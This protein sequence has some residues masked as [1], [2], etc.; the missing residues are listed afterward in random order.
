MEGTPFG[1]STAVLG[2]RAGLR[3]LLVA[4][5]AATV[6]LVLLAPAQ[7]SAGRLVATGHDADIHCTG[8]NQP[9]EGQCGFMRVATNYVRAGSSAPVLS[10]D[11]SGGSGF[12]GNVAGALDGAFGAGVVPRVEKCP[13]NPSD[14]FASEP[15]TTAR[16]S[17]IIVGSSCVGSLN[18]QDCFT[19]TPDSDAINARRDDIIAFF[20]AGGG[21]LALAGSEN[22]DGDPATGPDTYYG[23]LPLP[24]GGV[25]VN[26]PFCLTAVGRSL[27]LHD[28]SC[29]DTS[30]H[31]GTRDDINCCATHNSFTEPPGGS[32]LL[33]AE[34]D[35]GP[36]GV[37]SAGDAP[38][39]LIA[40]GIASGGTIVLPDTT[41]PDT[42]IESRPPFFTR[43][44]TP[45]FTFSSSEPGSRFECSIDGGPF[46]LCTS[47]FTT[48]RLAGGRHTFAVRAIDAA[49]NADPTP[50]TYVFE[51][52][53]ELSELPVPALGREF[54]VGPVPGSGPVFIAVRRRGSSSRASARASQKGLRFVPLTEARQVPMGSFLNTKR[55]T[56]Q[57]VSATG[58]SR[59]RRTQSGRFNAGVFQVLQSRTRRDRGLTELRLKGSNFR[60]CR[61]ARRGR[62]SAAQLSRRTIRR[63][64]GSARGRFRT[65]GRNSAATVRGTIWIT[66]DRCDGT[67]TTV[68]RGKVAV[69]DFRRKRTILVRSGKSYL[70]KAPG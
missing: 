69:R 39:T 57:L 12:P 51:I 59:G 22:G 37:L 19:S 23:F 45:T 66:A 62:A 29:P 5:S 26:G 11:C 68:K 55:G 44:N 34:R 54:N 61:T 10:L 60:R 41:P 50:T 16:Y 15:L 40:D 9:D 56:V 1:G 17:A 65:R 38:E 47:P 58:A 30:Q 49:G 14:N 21:I 64:R 42:P 7:A 52:A 53:V 32:A 31:A 28:Q 6:A 4:A 3:R 25:P 48:P 67:L 63:L 20:N 8:A 24:A 36:D 35:V 18:N 70:A 2:Q 27:G 13:S 33:V 46:F 43:D